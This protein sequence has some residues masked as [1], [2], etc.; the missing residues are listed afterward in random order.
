MAV[1]G[2]PVEAEILEV[3]LNP[4]LVVNGRSP[5]KIVAQWQNPETQKLHIFNSDNIWFDPSRFVSE[6]N[7]VRVFI[8]RQN[9]KRY[10]MDTGFLPELAE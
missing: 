8:D 10:S 9:P 6:L 2:Q 4:S 7:Q 1:S 5:W 3:R